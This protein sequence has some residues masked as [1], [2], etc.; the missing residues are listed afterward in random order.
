[1]VYAVVGLEGAEIFLGNLGG[2]GWA[3]PTVLVILL[4]GFPVSLVLAWA[5]DLTP[6]GVVR[7]RPVAEDSER[8]V[9]EDEDEAPVTPVPLTDRRLIVG[10]TTSKREWRCGTFSA[11]TR[12]SSPTHTAFTTIPATRRFSS[13]FGRAISPPTRKRVPSVLSCRRGSRSSSRPR[14]GLAPKSL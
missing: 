11:S 1:M 14:P 7:D 12:A 10:S 3:V 8:D 6:G 4:L 9:V 5:Y 2:A 13:A